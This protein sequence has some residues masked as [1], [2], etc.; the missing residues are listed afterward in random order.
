MLDHG[1][2]KPQPDGACDVARADRPADRDDRSEI[3][4]VKW[5]WADS[6]ECQVPGTK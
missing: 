5:I 3:G 4:G 2:G 6:V 1:F